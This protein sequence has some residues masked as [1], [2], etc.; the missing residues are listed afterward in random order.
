MSPDLSWLPMAE[1]FPGAYPS[2]PFCYVDYSGR[3]GQ[4]AQR[5][6]RAREELRLCWGCQRLHNRYDT[7]IEAEAGGGLTFYRQNGPRFCKRCHARRDV[8]K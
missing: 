2:R 7:V 3:C 6:R 4:A 5:L 1:S 8:A